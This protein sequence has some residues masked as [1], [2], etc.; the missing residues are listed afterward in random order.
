MNQLV[1][2]ALGGAIGSVMRYLFSVTITHYV[3]R[4]FPWGTLVVNIIGSLIMGYLF[5]KFVE[6]R[7][8]SN[9]MRSLL[10]IGLLGAFTTYSTFSIETLGLFESGLIIRAISN[11]LLNVFLCLLAV[12]CGVL[13]ARS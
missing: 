13:L 7:T 12:W 10:M 1:F 8:L 2:V 9:E 5:V 11:I 3:G 4:T 6:H